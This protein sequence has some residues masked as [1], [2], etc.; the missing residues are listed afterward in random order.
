ML[1]GFQTNQCVRRGE[2]EEGEGGERRSN[3]A[4]NRK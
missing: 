3:N 2:G 1:K 4:G